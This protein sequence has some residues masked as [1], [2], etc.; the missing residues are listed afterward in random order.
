MVVVLKRKLARKLRGKKKKKNGACEPLLT[1]SAPFFF[2]KRQCER[3]SMRTKHV[4]IFLSLEL[5]N[6]KRGL[7]NKSS[8]RSS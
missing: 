8:Y 6:A 4:A 2:Q 1:S 5:G 3:V 7:S